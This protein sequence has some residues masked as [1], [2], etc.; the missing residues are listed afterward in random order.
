MYGEIE[1]ECGH[2]P[3]FENAIDMAHIHYL[4]SDS[5]GNK[6]PLAARPAPPRPPAP[7]TSA[8]AIPLLAYA[9]QQQWLTRIAGVQEAAAC[10]TYKHLVNTGMCDLQSRGSR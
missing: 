3:V 10:H 1:F 4:H 6:V 8:R 5:F 9:T 7:R 2:W